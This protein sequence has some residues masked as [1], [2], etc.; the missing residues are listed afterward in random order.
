MTP[1]SVTIDTGSGPQTYRTF[2]DT[3]AE[4]INLV[5]TFLMTEAKATARKIK[6]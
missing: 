6:N 3:K 2:A 1:Y 5:T 4:A